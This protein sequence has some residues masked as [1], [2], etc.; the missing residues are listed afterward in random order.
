MFYYYAGS[1]SGFTKW[2]FSGQWDNDDV[3]ILAEKI[4]Y[5]AL[6]AYILSADC[7]LVGI[8]WCLYIFDYK[9]FHGSFFK[10]LLFCVDFVFDVF[11]A[12]FPLLL[13]GNNHLSFINAAAAINLDSSINLLQHYYQL[14]I[15]C[16]EYFEFASYK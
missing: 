8:L 2:V 16:L 1:Q 10:Y 7:L 11:Y 14:Y 9:T 4:E 5:A 15:L 6:F 13:I 3:V 12:I